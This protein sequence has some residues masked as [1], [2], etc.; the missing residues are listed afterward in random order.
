MSDRKKTVLILGTCDTKGEEVLYM[1]NV[2]ESQDVKSIVLDLGLT[3]DSKIIKVDITRQ[4]L[5]EAAGVSLDEL[6]CKAKKG[7]YEVSVEKLASG[8]KS[9]IRKLYENGEIDGVLAIGGTMGS[10]IGLTALRTLPVGFPKVLISTVA[11][12]DYLH[13]DFVKTDIILVQ[14]ISDFFGVNQW[15][16]RDLKRAALSICTVVKEEAPM[17]EGR[18]I[19]MT[20]NGWSARCAKVL[21]KHL[22]DHGYKVAMAHAVSMQSGILERLIRQGVIKG[23]LDLCHFEILHEVVGAPCHSKD[24]LAA[25]AEMGIPL[26][27]TPNTMGVFTMKTSEMHL[28]QEKGHFAIEHNEMV[29]TAQPTTEQMEKTAEIVCSRLN[30]SNGKVAYLVPRRG[31]FPYDQE[32]KMYYHPEG[33]AAYISVLERNLKSEINLEVLDCH[34]DDKQFEE[35]LCELSLEYFAEI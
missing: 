18:W 22:V 24:R 1:K 34:Y 26:I 33:R 35:R 30:K 32:G 13:P 31:F 19:G 12:S 16:K 11:I 29:G 10:T 25:S 5:A 14:P 17:E 28:Y 3:E 9:I 21:R 6:L 23:M 15:N 4:Q 20:A 8:S 2:V 27:L 7:R